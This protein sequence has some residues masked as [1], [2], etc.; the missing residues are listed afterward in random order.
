MNIP[1][2]W[3]QFQ[4]QADPTQISDSFIPTT[5]DTRFKAAAILAFCAWCIIPFHLWHSIHYYKVAARSK[6]LGCI[7]SIPPLFLLTIPLV[8]VVIGYAE[9]SS[10]ISS[11]HLGGVRAGNGWI[12]GLGFAPVVLILFLNI[13]SALRHPNDDLELIRQ[14]VTRGQASDAMLGVD[15]QMRKPRWWTQA[16]NDF[17]FDNDAKLRAL[18]YTNVG[19]RRIDDDQRGRNVQMQNLAR[20]HLD[21]EIQP[22]HQAEDPSTEY[23]RTANTI[24][25]QD[26]L[27]D[28]TSPSAYNERTGRANSYAQSFSSET[29]A[30]SQARPQQIRSMLDV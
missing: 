4:A 16:A 11:I 23:T 1:R 24:P 28:I 21:D 5:H 12:Y 13:T 15:R 18:A 22:A 6:T 25:R 29:T 7:R 8:L 20:Q 19:H 27:L 2:N 30:T 26:G 9:A 14:R 3:L 10:W 17:G